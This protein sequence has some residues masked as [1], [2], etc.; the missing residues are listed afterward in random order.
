MSLLPYLLVP[1]LSAFLRPYTSAL[2]TYLFTI[3]LLLFYPQIYFFVEEKL[4]PRPIEEAFT[5]RC[6]MIEFSFIFS[7]WLVFMPAALLLQVIFN[8]LFKRWR[9]TKEASE[10]INK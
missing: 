10:T 4:H 2:F 8:K 1:L 7:H 5:G 9:A 3:A 6:G